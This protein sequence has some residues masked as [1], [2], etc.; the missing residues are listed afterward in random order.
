MTLTLTKTLRHLAMIAAAALLVTA[1]G[2]KPLHAA[3]TDNPP[4]ADDGDKKKKRKA[5]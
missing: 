4:P 5:A 1:V 2:M 3:G